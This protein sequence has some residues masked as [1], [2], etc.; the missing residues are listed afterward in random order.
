MTDLNQ[1]LRPANWDQIVGQKNIVALCK[2]NI[3]Q[4]NF[5]KFSIFFGPSGVGKSCIAELIAKELVKD[6]RGIIHPNAVRKYNMA[7][8]LGKR[9]VLEVL[10][11]IFKY[12]GLSGKTVYIL[13]EVQVLKQSDE[14]SPF[15]EELTKIPE[16]IYVIMCTT[17][18]YDLLAELKNRAVLFQLETPSEQDC[19]RYIK[20]SLHRLGFEL[21]SLESMRT[22]A[23]LSNYVPRVIIKHIELLASGNTVDEE[24]MSEF[25]KVIAKN[26]TLAILEA[27]GS[28]NVGLFEY[29]SL[30]SSIKSKSTYSNIL[31]SLRDIVL[32]ILIEVSTGV[33]ADI[34]TAEER[35]K[36]KEILQI[37]D[38]SKFLMIINAISEVSSKN[39]E[40]QAGLLALVRLKTIVTGQTLAKASQRSSEQCSIAHI[41]ST[42][43]TKLFDEDKH[44]TIQRV[45]DD[46]PL[47]NLTGLSDDIFTEE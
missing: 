6:E 33:K 36:V 27:L 5:P 13:E 26:D 14:Q 39:V 18:I 34:F 8:Q 46:T 28:D 12:E 20:T 24:A 4:G 42:R 9:D 40:G 32:Q 45:S 31:F 23:A 44:I 47:S 1:L 25:F 41:T 17:R 10:K 21:M 11:H 29:T 16:D 19:I 3:A 37:C 35:N 15:L 2:K 22:L 7:A 43:K 38:E 30:V